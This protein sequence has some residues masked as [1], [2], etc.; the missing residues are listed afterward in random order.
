V[1]HL[2]PR[3]WLLAAPLLLGGCL[4]PL[5]GPAAW[6]GGASIVLTGGTPMDHVA[7]LITGQNCSIVRLERRESWCAAPA[8]TPPAQFCT[9]SLGAV[10]C[11]TVPP[12]SQ[13]QTA[14]PPPPR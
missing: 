11:W 6:V 8:T 4:E 1:P 14:D 13:R 12:I 3:S 9:R 5:L 7:S 2:P 10:D